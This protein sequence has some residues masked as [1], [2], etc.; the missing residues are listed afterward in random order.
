MEGQVGDSSGVRERKVGGAKP[1][2]DK[3]RRMPET[4][5]QQTLGEVMNLRE[6]KSELQ[7]KILAAQQ[8]I[9]SLKADLKAQ[10]TQE[11]SLDDFCEEVTAHLLEFQDRVI[12]MNEDLSTTK[13]TIVSLMSQQ[14]ALVHDLSLIHI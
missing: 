13:T 9:D 14:Q 1:E 4:K 10:E 5:V 11:H 8:E 12:M 3:V 7:G 6:E 2:K